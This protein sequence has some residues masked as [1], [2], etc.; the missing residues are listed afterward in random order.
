MPIYNA[1]IAYAPRP[2]GAYNPGSTYASYGHQATGEDIEGD[3][4]LN[5]YFYDPYGVNGPMYNPTG[6]GA[7]YNEGGL[8]ANQA[9]PTVTLPNT[10]Q[11]ASTGY[12]GGIID[13]IEAIFGANSTGG[14]VVDNNGTE[15]TGIPT[16]Y[17]PQTSGTGS[18]TDGNTTNNTSNN[19]AAGAIIGG[20]VAMS[21]FDDL[22]GGT[23]NDSLYA[24]QQQNADILQ[25]T[26]EL[27]ERARD[28]A[29]RLF[30]SAQNALTNAA[31]QSIGVNAQGADA[32]INAFTQGNQNA[33]RTQAQGLSGY[34][35]A[36]MG[37]PQDLSM[38][39]MLASL[40]PSV[41]VDTGFLQQTAPQ[42][43]SPT[44]LGLTSDAN[45]GGG[46]PGG[47]D[48]N[49]VGSANPWGA[50]QGTGPIVDIANQYLSGNLS[51]ADGVRQVIN[52]ANQMGLDIGQLSRMLGL[53]P[54]NILRLAQEHGLNFDNVTD[55]TGVAVQ[56]NVPYDYSNVNVNGPVYQAE[57]ATNYAQSEI[58]AVVAAL[59]SGQVTAQ[60][61]ADQ[62]G[63][64]VGQIQANLAALNA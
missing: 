9:L 28:D 38:A 15:A 24:N 31:N 21:L 42:M 54:Q 34:N 35:D 17:I 12:I 37:N 58:D 19:G 50:V 8:V 27:S 63:V 11:T 14:G 7:G 18:V 48:L 57:T 13:Q 44:A 3:A 39:N 40:P 20:G 29:F 49:G 25:R 52:Q 2:D 59:N 64:P 26:A 61:L 16:A 62:Y 60:Q 32:Q 33:Q 4:E 56:A 5:P 23:N 47:G 30:P 1:P 53:T 55:N 36:I 45:Y 46:F 41:S 6:V 43:L 22:F 10:G 51:E